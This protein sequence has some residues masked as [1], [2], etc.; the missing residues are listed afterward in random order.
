MTSLCRILSFSVYNN[1]K[2][3]ALYITFQDSNSGDIFGGKYSSEI[4]PSA[5]LSRSDIYVTRG[6]KVG[7]IAVKQFEKSFPKPQFEILRITSEN[8]KCDDYFD[9]Q[10]RI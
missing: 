4:L 5:I 7:E 2:K 3:S 8:H 9:K 10:S 6:E 1:R